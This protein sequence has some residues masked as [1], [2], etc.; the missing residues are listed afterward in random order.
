MA[1][2]FPD[3]GMS[4]LAGRLGITKGAISQTAKR[5]IEKGYL[6]RA[7]VAGDGKTI[8]LRLTPAGQDAFLW[9]REY[10]ALV[11][12]RISGE[13]GRL[14]SREREKVFAILARLEAVFDACPE[15]REQVTQRLRA[16]K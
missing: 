13:F 3:D 1:G 15:T 4:S 9:H 14:S 16:M 8:L 12:N 6:E 10:H 5:L 7:T 2:R 11:N